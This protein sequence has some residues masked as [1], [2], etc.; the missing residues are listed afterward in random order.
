VAD[1]I[2]NVLFLGTSNSARSIFAEVLIN[3]WGQGKFKGFSAGSHPK[4][5]LN[6]LG[7]RI[8]A[9]RGFTHAGASQQE[10]G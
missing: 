10:L 4:A 6:P 7:A 5:A 8:A 9:I 1:K 2:Y 3:R